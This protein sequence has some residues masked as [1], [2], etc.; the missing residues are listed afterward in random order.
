MSEQDDLRREQGDLREAEE[1][2]AAALGFVGAVRWL[3]YQ[4]DPPWDYERPWDEK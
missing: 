4:E 3:M 2:I 1:L